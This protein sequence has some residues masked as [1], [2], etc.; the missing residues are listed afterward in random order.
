MLREMTLSTMAVMML[1]SSAFAAPT[2]RETVKNE[3]L[4]KEKIEAAGKM[5]KTSG[6]ARTEVLKM[7]IYREASEL[8]S[9]ANNAAKEGKCDSECVRSAQALEEVVRNKEKLGLNDTIKPEKVVRDAAKKLK[10]GKSIEV[11]MKESIE[12]NGVK[13]DKLLECAGK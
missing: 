11:A 1:A 13:K 9:A 12:E 8:L 10:E 4:E 3:K 7:R 2:T 5:E 6:S